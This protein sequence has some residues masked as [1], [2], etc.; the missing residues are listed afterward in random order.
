MFNVQLLYEQVNKI[1]KS[2]KIINNNF[3]SLKEVEDFSKMPASQFLHNRN[4]AALFVDDNGINRVYFYLDDLD[5]AIH[6]KNLLDENKVL[7]KP[8][9][10]DCLG[11]EIFLDGLIN[12][13]ANHGIKL[14]K[15]MN[16]W[17]A[18]KVTNLLSY[19]G[20][21]IR[22]A[23]PKDLT[24]IIEVLETVMD[25]IIAHLPTKIKL[26]NLIK[27]NLIF[28]AEINKEIVGVYCMEYVGKNSIYLYQDA[29]L[30]KYQGSGI[31]VKL[32]HFALNNYSNM[33][34]YTAWIEENNKMSEK[35]NCFVGLKKD[36]LKDYVF[37]Y[38]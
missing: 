16:R 5:N 36:I 28:C 30:P 14:Y 18:V 27:E 6:L 33:N 19:T 26:E 20:Q 15:K 23:Q 38:D 2:K 3:L 29:V 4:A 10:I 32:L 25:P 7:K 37:I 34:R 1:R 21:M 31:G 17:Q 8:Y 13:F 9:V 22:T 24:E 12:C 11:N 35:M